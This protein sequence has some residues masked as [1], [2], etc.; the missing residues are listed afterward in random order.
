MFVDHRKGGAL[1]AR[2]TPN[3]P[4]SRSLRAPYRRARF[5]TAEV[6]FD[7]S[8]ALFA[9]EAVSHCGLRGNRDGDSPSRVGDSADRSEA[10]FYAVEGPAV[11]HG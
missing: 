8:P 3:K 9:P 2:R 5:G 11:S 6:K 1:V 4:R 10:R 7:G